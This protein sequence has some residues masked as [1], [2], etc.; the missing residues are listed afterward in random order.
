MKTIEMVI[1]NCGDGSNGIK[2][3][4]DPAVVDRMIELADDGDEQYA[5]GD[6]LQVRELKFPDDFDI[7]A[8]LKLNHLRL[9]TMGDM[10]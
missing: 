9:T 4:G 3:V 6:G 7:E 10:R 1:T 8:W 2:W 5:S